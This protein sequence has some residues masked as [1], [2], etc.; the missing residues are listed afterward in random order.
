MSLLTIIQDVCDRIGLARPS[1]VVGSSDSQVRNLLGLAQQEVRDLASRAEWQ[2]LIVEKTFTAT[3]TAAQSGAI[4]TDFDRMVNGSFWNRTRDNYIHGPMTPQEWQAIQATFAPNVSEA[5]RIRGSSILITPTP[6]AG[7]TY[8]YEYI[9]KYVVGT[10]SSTSPTL[11][12]FAADTDIPYVREELVTLGVIWRF[13]KARG[14]DYGESMQT[15]ELAVKRAKD[16][17]GAAPII[18]MGG[19]ADLTRA[20]RGR[21][22]DGDWNL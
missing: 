10:A 20:P 21:I 1:A 8:A 17:D 4:P 3:A 5:F 9:T 22:P 6:T 7:D 19:P 18:V 16:R 11:E 13:Q 12:A 15:Y 14:L 2:A